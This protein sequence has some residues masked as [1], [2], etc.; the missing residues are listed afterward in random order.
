MKYEDHPLACIFPLMTEVE[1]A[2]LGNDIAKIGQ[3]E[4]LWLLNG[5]ILDGRNRYRA[6]ELKGIEPVVQAWCGADPLAFVL[7]KNLHRR[8]LNESQ[9]AMVAARIVKEKQANSPTNNDDSANLRTSAASA[10]DLLN[11]SSRSVDSASK[12]L[13]DGE[14]ELV[15]AVDAGKAKVSAAAT[16]AD[17]PPKEQR[18]AVKTGTVAAK[19]KEV[20]A[21][22]IRCEL[23]KRKGF[24]RDDCSECNEMRKD[25]KKAKAKPERLPDE[26]AFVDHRTLPPVIVPVNPDAEGVTSAEAGGGHPF[27]D[28]KTNTSAVSAEWTRALK[29]DGEDFARLYQYCVWCG[30]VDH[31]PKKGGSASLIVLKGLSKIIELA[32]QGGKILTQSKV[33]DAWA[34]ASGGKPYVPP[35]TARRRKGVK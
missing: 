2:E 32:G 34:L 12:V 20:K 8:H 14:D 31:D 13:R 10:A 35:L 19:A 33:L 25:Q 15:A 24:F 11:V 21:A 30:L 27:L 7:S 5:K 4:P 18:A 1:I 28:L 6:C 17:L 9:R 23:C 3:Q 16:V 26:P 29:R 22:T